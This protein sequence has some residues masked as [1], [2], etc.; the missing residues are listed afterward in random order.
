MSRFKLPDDPVSSQWRGHAH[1]RKIMMQSFGFDVATDSR[2][3]EQR[4]EFRAEY[5]LSVYLSEE[6]RLLAHAIARDKKFLR[7]FIPNGKGKHAP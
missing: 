5:K 6:Q 3:G 4:A 1:K 7:S 2:M